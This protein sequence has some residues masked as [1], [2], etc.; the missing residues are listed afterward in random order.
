MWWVLGLIV[1][2]LVVWDVIHARNKRAEEVERAAE[3]ER[4]KATPP[5][6]RASDTRVTGYP[7]SAPPRSVPRQVQTAAAPAPVQ[8]NDNSSLV[9]GLIIGSLLNSSG[10]SHSAPLRSEDPAP[11]IVPEPQRSTYATETRSV[12]PTPSPAYE[13]SPSYDTGMSSSSSSFDS[14]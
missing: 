12:E 10:T 13:P 3:Y 2:V 8:S 1:L 14:P 4:W 6:L 9:T 7:I 11:S 5:T